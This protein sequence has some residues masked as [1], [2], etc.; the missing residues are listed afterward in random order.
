MHEILG[1]SLGEVPIFFQEIVEV[2][3][4]AEF[5]NKIVSL[6]RSADVFKEDDVVV[7]QFGKD[8]DLRLLQLNAFSPVPSQNMLLVRYFNS[9]GSFGAFL[10]PNI[11]R[12]KR[13]FTQNFGGVI[14]IHLKIWF[15][16]VESPDIL[17]ND[18]SFVGLYNYR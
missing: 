18:F 1:Q 17:L 6:L 5:K 4:V 11:H 9:K 14:L 15:P 16:R 8:L 12:G 3:K 13:P 7:L 2:S 10:L